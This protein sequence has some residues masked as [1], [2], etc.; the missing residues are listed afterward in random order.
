[1]GK[2]IRIPKE[3]LWTLSDEQL[4]ELKAGGIGHEVY[5]NE[6]FVYNLRKSGS[7]VF[8]CFVTRAPSGQTTTG[9]GIEIKKCAKKL[10][11]GQLS[12]MVDELEWFNNGW[13]LN[14]L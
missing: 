6:E 8:V 4:T 10:G 3:Y 1:M 11:I 9:F 12:V 14:G 13:G 5:S 7:V 2:S